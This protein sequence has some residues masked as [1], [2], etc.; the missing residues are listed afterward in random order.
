MRLA[1]TVT[2]ARTDAVAKFLLI[3]QDTTYAG[4]LT[5]YMLIGVSLKLLGITFQVTTFNLNL[6]IASH[7]DADGV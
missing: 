5:M 3:G 2:S 1:Q 4:N 6:E 7:A